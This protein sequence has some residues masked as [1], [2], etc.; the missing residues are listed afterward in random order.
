MRQ[1]QRQ[2]KKYRHGRGGQ[3]GQRGEYGAPW[4][5]GGVYQGEG[6]G[7]SSSTPPSS[8][9][10]III[11]TINFSFFPSIIINGVLFLKLK[12]DDGHNDYFFSTCWVVPVCRQC[13][14]RPKKTK[15]RNL[16]MKIIFRTQENHSKSHHAWSILN[17]SIMTSWLIDKAKYITYVSTMVAIVV[18]L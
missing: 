3:K 1:R 14:S 10:S 8:F 9:I 7:W 4:R 2:E 12:H 17:V 6:R 18:Y 16:Q 11:V 5:R 13:L 15:S